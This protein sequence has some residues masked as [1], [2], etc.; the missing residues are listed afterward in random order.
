[1]S[2]RYEASYVNT[3]F[4]MRMSHGVVCDMSHSYVTWLIQTEAT[5]RYDA[6]QNRWVMTHSYVTWLIYLCDMTLSHVT[7]LI[8]MW[9]VSFRRRRH[10]HM[11]GV[12]QCRQRLPLLATILVRW[13][14]A[15]VRATAGREIITNLCAQR[16]QESWNLWL[17]AV[18]ALLRKRQVRVRW[19]A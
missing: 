15:G 5:H 11:K 19:E 13:Q 16:L 8:Y 3:S 1:M 12:M 18:E 17:R 7:W 9:H 10:A 4:H 6:T 2:R 14:M